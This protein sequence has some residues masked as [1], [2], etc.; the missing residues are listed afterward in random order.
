MKQ[1]QLLLVQMEHLQRRYQVLH[2]GRFTPAAVYKHVL[3]IVPV[4]SC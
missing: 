2:E 3:C 1:R 4:Q